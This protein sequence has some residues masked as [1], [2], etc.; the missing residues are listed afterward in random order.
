MHEAESGLPKAAEGQGVARVVAITAVI[1]LVAGSTPGQASGFTSGW[2]VVESGTSEDLLTAANFGGQVWAFGTGGVILNSIDNGISWENTDSPTTSDI[3]YSDS[4]FGSL[5]I[6]GDSGLVL[7]KS[8]VDAEWT[9]ISLPG[10]SQVNGISLTGGQS[11]IAVG[12]NGTIWELEEGEWTEISLS[13]ESD[14]LGVSFIDENLGIVVG[15]DGT[16]LFSDDGGENWEYREA[17]EGASDS[18]IVSVEFYSSTRIYAITDDGSILIS[19]SNVVTGTDVGY[20]WTLVEFERHYPPGTNEYILGPENLDVELTSVEVVSTSK[21]LMTGAGGYLSMSINGGTIVSQQI[22]PLG[23]ETSFNGIVMVT[24]F[25]GIAIG[26]GGS[27]LWTDNAGADDQV[28][29]VVPEYGNFGVFVDETKEM[30]LSGFIATLKIVA[31]GIVL[32]FFL[33][34]TLAMCKTSPTSLRYIVERYEPRNVR[35]VGIPILGAGIFQ[36]YSAIPG[37]T[38][39]GLQGIEY[40]FLPVGAPE[41]FLRI[42]LGIALTFVGLLFLSND[43]EFAKI[44]IK[45]ISLNPWR[46]RPLNTIATVYTDFFRNTPLIVQFLFIHFGV[47][48]GALIQGPGL[49]IFSFENLEGN[50]NFLTD[51][52]ARYDYSESNYG[53]LVGGVLYDSAFISAICAL[54]FNSGAYQCET[55][56]GAIQAI[57]SAQME[58]GRSI[59]LT[60]LQTMRRVIMPQAIRICIPPMGNEM[61]NL[62]LNSS[63]AMIIGYAELTRQGKL[64][65]ASTFQYAYAWGMVLISYFVVT[66]TLAL[67]LRWMEEKTRIPGLGMTGGN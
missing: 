5:I 39:L 14:L 56:R 45:S 7:L 43:G 17:P 34:V 30:F 59:G 37:T 64:I 15:S 33:G 47:R 27:I 44:R 19:M 38:D 31:F 51:I 4:D 10:D 49:D 54:G 62:V 60:Y 2:E 25:T 50:H 29:F 65:V 9:D 40:I 52:F 21:L 66:W 23:N 41:S 8:G 36:I 58:A 48:L 63:L 67:F 26:D 28:G 57:P 53:T 42:L 13:I 55:I 61:V 11:A 20:V 46:V 18:N 32:G 35:I 16:I 12:N 24:G 3:R 1:L 22:N 6:S